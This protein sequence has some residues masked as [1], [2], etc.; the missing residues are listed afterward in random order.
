[1]TTLKTIFFLIFYKKFHLYILQFFREYV[2][3]LFFFER[4]I[5]LMLQVVQMWLNESSVLSDIKSICQSLG[6]IDRDTISGDLPQEQTSSL[7][8]DS[9]VHII[10]DQSTFTIHS[11][12]SWSSACRLS[13]NIEYQRDIFLRTKR[14]NISASR[15]IL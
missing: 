14:K 15:M 2:I 10:A 3:I 6:F 11:S 8:E 4:Q 9:L 7:G 13:R 12:S 5:N 1:M